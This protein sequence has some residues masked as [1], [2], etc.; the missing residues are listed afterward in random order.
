M[1][2]YA[3]MSDIITTLGG[4]AAVARA[5]GIKPP[6]VIGWQGRVPA[7]RRA[8]LEHAFYPLVTVEQLGDDARWRRVPDPSWPHPAGRPYKNVVTRAPE[9]PAAAQA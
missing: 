9:L 8:D 7:D 4:P 1:P 5:L 2:Y 6:S 3:G